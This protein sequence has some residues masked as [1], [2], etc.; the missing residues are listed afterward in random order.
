M[1]LRRPRSFGLQM[2]RKSY[3][4]SGVMIIK[5][6]YCVEEIIGLLSQFSAINQAEGSDGRR[7][8]VGPVTERGFP[9]KAAE[10][11]Q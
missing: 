10:F 9:E 7:A 11:R 2:I 5:C 6:R 4:S 3:D 8:V 1:T